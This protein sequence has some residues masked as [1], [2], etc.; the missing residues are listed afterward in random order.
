MTGQQ[1]L[2]LF[3]FTLGLLL[4]F[5]GCTLVPVSAAAAPVPPTPA[6]AAAAAIIAR[7]SDRG[8]CD[9]GRAIPWRNLENNAAIK[10]T[11]YSFNKID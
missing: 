11:R 9:L 8:R 2:F 3:T 6:A 5:E 10:S 1:R 7:G 4:L